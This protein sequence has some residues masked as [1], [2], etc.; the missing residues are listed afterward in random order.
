MSKGG[1]RPGSGRPKGAKNTKT[2][3]FIEKVSASGLMPLDYL[4]E[5]LRNEAL[6]PDD[7]FKAAV[8]AAP[9]VHAKLA[10]IE[11]STDPDKPLLMQILSG[12][13][14]G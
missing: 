2:K 8:A 3:E 4:L 10:A 14:R 5:T 9:Y 6:E 7:R 12:V 13:E 11:H 1:A